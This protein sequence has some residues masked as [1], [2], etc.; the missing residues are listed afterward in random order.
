MHCHFTGQ[1]VQWGLSLGELSDQNPTKPSYFREKK[2]KPNK[3]K[4]PKPALFLV[5]YSLFVQN[6]TQAEHLY[7]TLCQIC[8]LNEQQLLNAHS[9][10]SAATKIR[11]T[12]FQ[13]MLLLRPVLTMIL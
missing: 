9:F 12:Q 7:G 10:Q 11:G 1:R 13:N 3:T 5:A 8:K 4:N 2:T 6:N